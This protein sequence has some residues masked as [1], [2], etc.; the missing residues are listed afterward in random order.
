[1][2]KRRQKRKLLPLLPNHESKEKV[3]NYYLNPRVFRYYYATLH[4]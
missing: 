1:M 3:S 4:W 2:K